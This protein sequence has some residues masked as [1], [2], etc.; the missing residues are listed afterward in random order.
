MSRSLNTT[1]EDRNQVRSRQGTT[2]C[3]FVWPALFLGL[4]GGGWMI[5]CSKSKPT[6]P[7]S[8][9]TILSYYPTSLLSDSLNGAITVTFEQD[10]DSASIT[11]S[12]LWVDGKTGSVTYHNR[13]AAFHPTTP[14]DHNAT[15]AAHVGASVKGAN[16]T[17]MG[18]NFDWTFTTRGWTLY[19]LAKFLDTALRSEEGASAVTL[20]AD[21]TVAITGW[22]GP[23]GSQNILLCRT[24]LN[25][26]QLWSKTIDVGGYGYA[27]GVVEMSDRSLVIAG[28]GGDNGASGLLIKTDASG[29]MLWRKDFFGSPVTGVVVA[30]D[31][32]LAAACGATV[33]KFSSATGDPLWTGATTGIV[34]G[35]CAGPA[36]GFVY[37]SLIQG[38]IAPAKSVCGG[39]LDASGNSVWFREYAHG[40]Y[41]EGFSTATV[42]PSNDGNYLLFGGHAQWS[43]NAG[44]VVIKVT[45]AGDSLWR[46]TDNFGDYGGPFTAACRYRDG[47]AGVVPFREDGGVPGEIVSFSSSGQANVYPMSDYRNLHTYE[48]FWVYGVTPRTA[49]ELIAVGEVTPDYTD[50]NRPKRMFFLRLRYM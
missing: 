21:G 39:R 8:P 28:Q 16:G 27:T 7:P 25:G 18:K 46:V 24:D 30:G 20:C 50:P 26:V 32:N 47:A 4:V 14:F 42:V 34:F 5:S 48:Y 49:D 17:P 37:T 43:G 31:G 19:P 11:S 33:V 1:G 38:D 15:Y 35:L 41:Q 29:N 9:P 44:G 12:S 36:G 6:Q 2:R 40:H 22:I 10:M 13:V 45:P 23:Y 3:H